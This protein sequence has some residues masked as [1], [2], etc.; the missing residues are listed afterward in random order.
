[1]T[2]LV[3]I[4]STPTKKIRDGKTKKYPAWTV[5]WRLAGKRERKQFAD[6]KEAQEFAQ[7]KAGEIGNG[8]GNAPSLSPAESAEYTEAKKKLG[9]V[10]LS[11]AVAFYNRRNP[12][13]SKLTPTEITAELL[14][15]KKSDGMSEL[16]LKDLRVRLGKFCRS[17]SCPLS[18][19][20]GADIDA[21]LRTQKGGGRNRNNYR[22][23]IQNLYS[24][25]KA[26]RHLPA[27]WNELASVP[28]AR[29][30]PGRIQ[31][32]TPLEMRTLLGAA[33]PDLA[34]F[35]A[36][37]GFAGMRHEEIKRQQWEDIQ[38]RRRHLR[39]TWVK[40]NTPANRLVPLPR[41]AVLWLS[42]VARVKGAVCTFNA[43]NRLLRLAKGC[44][45]KWK[46][47]GLR[48]SFISYR[49]AATRNVN[50]VALEA[51]TSARKIHSN[52]LEL[53]TAGDARKWFKICPETVRPNVVPMKT[54]RKTV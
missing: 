21:W 54:L 53:V 13:A 27:D 38:L 14:A 35:I 45:L 41:C 3:Q 47:N 32:F 9:G 28:R 42:P 44:E 50:Q 7:T 49:V 16:H 22:L 39:V 52:Y 18:N 34:A 5:A 6:K 30:K 29:E 2:R 26:R 15:S 51:G 4:Y 19:I 48:H 11:E 1:M 24:F 43:S 36:L 25:A 31:I 40:G 46:K 33:A 12:G 17:F 20:S 23:V 37:A 10:P 8:Q